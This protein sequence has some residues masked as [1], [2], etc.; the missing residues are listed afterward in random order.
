V[1][2][3]IF[4]ET[5]TEEERERL[6]EARLVAVWMYRFIS[7]RLRQREATQPF[8]PKH[9]YGMLDMDRDWSRIKPEEQQWWIEAAAEA[10]QKFRGESL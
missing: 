5:A 2:D 9:R 4:D 6:A 1:S 8:D 10:L 3:S 7:D